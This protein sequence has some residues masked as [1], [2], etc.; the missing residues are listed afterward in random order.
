MEV[1]QMLYTED[2]AVI[3]KLAMSE[4]RNIAL[5]FHTNPDVFNQSRE[6]GDGIYVWT[7]TS[8]QSKLV[9][10]RR[11]FQLYDEDPTG[12]VFYLH[13]DNETKLLR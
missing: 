8:T 1:I 10:L 2:K 6:I 7:N 11:L 9:V 4:E 3:T 12:L 13:D 5:Y